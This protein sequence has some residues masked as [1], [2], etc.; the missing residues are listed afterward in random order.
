MKVGL[1]Y[2]SLTKTGMRPPIKE[3]GNK[4]IKLVIIVIAMIVFLAFTGCNNSKPPPKPPEDLPP[5]APRYR[6]LFIGVSKYD[7]YDGAIDLKTPAPNTEKLKNLFSKFRFG[8]TKTPVEKI[9]TLTNS[10]AS[11]EGIFKA[12]NETFKDAK[13][14]DVSYFYYMGHGNVRLSTPIITPSDYKYTDFLSMITVH[15]LKE[16]LDKIP[17]HK[18]IFLET[19]HGGNFIEKSVR[20]MDFGRATI[21]VFSQVAKGTLNRPP[22]QVITSSAGTQLSWENQFW[23][24]SYFCKPLIEGCEGKADF[25]NNGKI[26]LDEL[27]NY[28]S[29]WIG[30]QNLPEMQTPQIYP[31]GSGFIICEVKEVN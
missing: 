4:V 9:S 8:E 24:F 27:H 1:R 7:N 12:I 16:A 2:L 18:V 20:G 30:E 17:G 5:E 31:E 19:C 22:Y 13:D 10:D 29:G 15:E 11:K 23:N 6:A 21:S 26:T 25:D 14:N 3:R 28:I